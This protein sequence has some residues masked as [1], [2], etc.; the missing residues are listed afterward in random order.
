MPAEPLKLVD[1]GATVAKETPIEAAG[2]TTQPEVS[3]H[4]PLNTSTASEAKDAAQ[5]TMSAE[6]PAVTPEAAQEA[7][8]PPP[9]TPQKQKF[10][11]DGGSSTTSTP[12]KSETPRKKR[13]SLIG[14][15]KHMFHHDK[16]DKDKTRKASNPQ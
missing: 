10:P 13:Q 5:P 6:A 14:K 16:H 7:A 12:S 9:E 2:E 3:T 15:I 1:E 11:S 4:I 8:Q